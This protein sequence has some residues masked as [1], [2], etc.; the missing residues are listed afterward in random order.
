MRDVEMPLR[1]CLVNND[2]DFRHMDGIGKYAFELSNE[3][4]KY[5]YDLL[6]LSLEDLRHG[7]KFRKNILDDIIL[8]MAARKAL[9][10]IQYKILHIMKPEAGFVFSNRTPKNPVIVTWHD[11]TRIHRF[12]N[13]LEKKDIRNYVY[14]YYLK[15]SYRIADAIISVS[16][17][18]RLDIIEWAQALGIY[19]QSK[20]LYVVN[21]G[22]SKEFLEYEGWDG[23]REDFIYVGKLK[24]PVPKLLKIFDTISRTL[25]SSKLHIFTPTENAT[26]LIQHEFNL[27]GYKFRSKVILHFRGTTSEIRD[28]LR[29]SVALIHPVEEEGFGSTIIESL[30][31][32]TPVILLKDARISPEVAKYC[33]TPEMEEIPDTCLKL[34]LEQTGVSKDV[35]KYAR[36]FTYE[37]TAREIAKIY[38]IFV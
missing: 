1:I 2:F 15:R 12:R 29:K 18:T 9:S 17:Q 27:H 30:A 26:E 35:L 37:K 24:D 34:Y 25:P 19:D 13:H 21:P 32:G 14:E 23:R 28:V 36:S 7:N 5:N 4:N 31:A 33:L 11:L 16:T 6:K 10:Q 38:E 22:I 20:E 3:L 8:T